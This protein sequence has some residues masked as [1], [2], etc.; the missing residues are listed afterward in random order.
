MDREPLALWRRRFHGQRRRSRA[1]LL[2]KSFLFAKHRQGVIQTMSTAMRTPSKVQMLRTPEGD[3]AD[4]SA[5]P[6][7]HLARAVTLHLAG[8]REEALKNLQR[9]VTNNEGSAEIYR[10]MGHI[11]FELGAFDDAAKSYRILVQVKPQYSMGWFN[12]AVCLER[13]GVWEDASQAFHRACT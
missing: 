6:Q 9:A 1:P 5:G 13:A 3:G 7:G 11:Q 2:G 12:L 4:K 8:K 10:A